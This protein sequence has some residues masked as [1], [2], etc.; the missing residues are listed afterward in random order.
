[1]IRR[2]SAGIFIALVCAEVGAVGIV[3]AASVGTVNGKRVLCLLICQRPDGTGDKESG[4]G[5]QDPCRLFFILDRAEGDGEELIGPQ[6]IV[7]HGFCSGDATG[8]VEAI[9][10]IVF[11]G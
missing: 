9:G 1:M 5:I 8:A 3:E 7:C 2:F 10:K 6:V 4:A 11:P